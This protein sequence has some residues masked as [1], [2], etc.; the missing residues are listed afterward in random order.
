MKI[1]FQTG[2]HKIF[3]GIFIFAI[4]TL[5]PVKSQAQSYNTER[6]TLSNYLKRMYTAAP[7]EGVRVVQ[8]YE[9]TYLMSVISFDPSKYNDERTLN[10]IA[11][12]KAM[13][14][15][16]RYF[17]GSTITSELIIYTTDNPDKSTE[18]T[19][20]EK[21]NEN[22]IGYVRKLEQLTNFSYDN[23]QIFIFITEINENES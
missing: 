16:S 11:S 10:R 20:I 2:R 19:V 6:T 15:A 23:R 13:S 1:M 9:K 5:I 8:D 4:S 21:I 22:S 18:T 17:N 3:F 12:V 7:F 14:Q